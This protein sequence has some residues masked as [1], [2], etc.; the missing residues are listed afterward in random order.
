MQEAYIKYL[1]KE[2]GY[3]NKIRTDFPDVFEKRA[4][5][6]RELGCSCING[7]FLDELEPGRGRLDME[8]IPECSIMC[9][10]SEHSGED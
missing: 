2:M 7:I 4:K 6:E 9:Y 5:L 10:F 8:I 3:W 1:Q